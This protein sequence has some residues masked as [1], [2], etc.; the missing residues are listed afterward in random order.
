MKKFFK[1]I[2]VSLLALLLILLLLAIVQPKDV[3]IERSLTIKSPQ[4]A[5]FNQIKYFKNWVNWSPWVAREPN[6]KLIYLGEDGQINSAYHWKGDD[7]GE[8]EMTN[9]GIKDNQLDFRLQ[10]IKPWE[11]NA[12]GF[13]KTE[14]NGDG[15]VKVT[16]NMISHGSFPMN[17]L[18]YFTEKVVGNDFE[19]GLKLL[20]A[21]AEAHPTVALSQNDIVEKEFPATTFASLRK[22]IS[23]SEM[24]QFSREAFAQL[25]V[26][27]AEHINSAA[28]TIYYDWDE[29]NMITDMAPAF[30]IKSTESVKGF[31]IVNIPTSNSCQINY[32]G[33]YSGIGKSHEIMGQYIAEKGKKL[34]YVIEQYLVGPANEIDS[35]KWVTNIIYLLK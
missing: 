1:V 2:G 22:K 7:L 10:F 18:N 27:L 33:G 13:I 14:D 11:G 30:A 20:K 12:D 5:I 6:V 35:N 24:E 3:L 28:T 16:W 34:S 17:A 26:G 9:T 21:Y 19:E 4:T 23:F 8:G 29:K 31:E 32:K 25:S 15:T